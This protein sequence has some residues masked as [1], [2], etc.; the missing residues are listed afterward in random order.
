MKTLL[1][2]F[3]LLFSSSVVAEEYDYNFFV[4]ILSPHLEISLDDNSIVDGNWGK[5]QILENDKD[6]FYFYLNTIAPTSG[7]LYLFSLENNKPVFIHKGDYGS[8]SKILFED[9]NKD[10]VKEIVTQ[11]AFDGTGVKGIT[12]RIFFYKKDQNNF[13]SFVYGHIVNNFHGPSFLPISEDEYLLAKLKKIN[14][15]GIS[16]KHHSITK[17][18]IPNGS[19]PSSENF[20]KNTID[21]YTVSAQN[22]NSIDLVVEVANNIA[23]NFNGTIKCENF[24]CVITVRSSNAEW[25]SKKKEIINKEIIDIVF[26]NTPNDYESKAIITANDNAGSIKDYLET[27]FKTFLSDFE[28]TWSDVSSFNVNFKVS[29]LDLNNDGNDEVIF[30]YC[31]DIFKNCSIYYVLK[32][33][34]VKI[35]EPE[36]SNYLKKLKDCC[37]IEPGSSEAKKELE[38]KQSKWIIIGRIWNDGK[39]Q[40]YDTKYNE[41]NILSLLLNNDEKVFYVYEENEYRTKR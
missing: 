8:I 15:G 33:I 24:V 16:W 26:H 38:E 9:R 28:N 3:V 10:G 35:Q 32:N 1:T 40:M 29:S 27:A 14:F 18:L 25:V 20:I 5:F 11:I 17:L 6:F 19:F 7:H 2:L 41:Y 4:N 21:T 22:E 30:Y 12:E 39:L 13:E 36:L 34:Q 31:A 23:K 37:G